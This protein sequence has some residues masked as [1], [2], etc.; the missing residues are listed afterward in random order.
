MGY[1]LS[2]PDDVLEPIQNNELRVKSFSRH[3]VDEANDLK[4]PIN[5]YQHPDKVANPALRFRHSY[6]I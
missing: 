1:G 6:D 2:R 5:I 3:L 4:S